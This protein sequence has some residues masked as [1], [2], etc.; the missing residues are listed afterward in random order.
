MSASSVPPP[1]WVPPASAQPAAFDAARQSG[2]AGRDG[3]PLDAR[4]LGA[5]LV[6]GIILTL[7]GEALKWFAG[8]SL[9]TWLAIVVI[10][11]AYFCLWETATGTTPGKRLFGLQVVGLDGDHASPSAVAGRSAMRLVDHLFIP[12]VGLISLYATGRR[13]QRVG[14]LAADTLVV[15]RADAP[16]DPP[17]HG[18]G[19]VLRIPTLLLVPAVVMLGL[20]T[21][22]H[23][24]GGYQTQAEETCRAA[25]Y[26]VRAQDVSP[27]EY[28]RV[29]QWRTAQLEALS[30]PAHR[31]ADHEVLVG[32]AREMRDNYAALLARAAASDNWARTYQAEAG[33]LQARAQALGAQVVA[34]G[35][36]DC[37]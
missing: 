23:L 11:I 1:G 4:R 20:T 24:P 26:Q 3:R 22:G 8:P 37:R 28:L 27:N 35:Y 12:F 34:H 31:R 33:Q 15:R 9:W 32:A 10:A 5:L 25:V 7:A 17:R 6:D 29:S 13:R 30:P 18:V 21:M 36:P 14:D 16:S 2:V 19:A